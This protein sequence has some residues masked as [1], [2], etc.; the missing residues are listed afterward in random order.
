MMESEPNT[1]PDPPTAESC[2]RAVPSPPVVVPDM[3]ET[4][5]EF[6]ETPVFRP[7]DSEPRLGKSD[8]SDKISLD[9]VFGNKEIY[10][11]LECVPE[12]NGADLE[13]LVKFITEVDLIIST[14]FIPALDFLKCLTFKFK[15]PTRNWWLSQLNSSWTWQCA[16]EELLHEYIT[17]IDKAMLGEKF[18]NRKQRPNE[19]YIDYVEDIVKYLPLFAP[20]LSEVEVVARLW[21]NQ[22]SATLNYM[23]YRDPPDTLAA[24]KRLARQF[25]VV[26][27]QRSLET[28]ASRSSIKT[29]P[30]PVA[31][32][33]CKQVGHRIA[34]CPVRPV[35]GNTEPRAILPK[36]D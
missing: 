32:F 29:E 25:R 31:C 15:G 14:P 19:D 33:Y 8:K 9:S 3:E 7:E 35:R 12:F 23:Q 1:V 21:I 17:P 34:T 11:M 26:S 24:L 28:S 13:I 30:V 10:D 36:Q 22:N 2:F 5:V 6:P 27:R 18:I 16:K 4:F 20:S